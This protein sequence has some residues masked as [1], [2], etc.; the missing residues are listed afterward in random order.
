VARWL[1]VGAIMIAPPS[2][3]A[4]D[5]TPTPSARELWDAYPLQQEPATVTPTPQGAGAGAGAE[6]SGRRTSAPAERGNGGDIPWLLVGVLGTAVALA[7][8]AGLAVLRRRGSRQAIG[9]ADAVRSSAPVLLAA[10]VAA[11]SPDE[12]PR[13]PRLTALASDP[14]PRHD[15]PTEADPPAAAMHPPDPEQPWTAELEWQETGRGARFCLVAHPVGGGTD[16][17]IAASE[18]LAWPPPDAKAVRQMRNEV[19]QM[20]AALLAA[21]WAPLPP[22]TSW[23][24]KRFAWAPVAEPV[25]TGR[26][27]RDP[28]WPPGSE[29][30]H[31]CEI[32]W[33]PGYMNSRFKVVMFEPGRR[34]S[35]T[36][37]TSE[38]FK[39]QLMA[40]PDPG[41]PEQRAEVERLHQL[42][43]AAGWEPAG[44]GAMW[45]ALRF[46]RRHES[47]PPA[48]LEPDAAVTGGGR[49]RGDHAEH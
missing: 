35:T 25:S 30:L 33:Q 6:P 5:R 29:D 40:D 21:G 19:A 3:V 18:P 13:T 38:V 34:R 1:L 31:R 12:R 16:A 28:E 14:D 9:S 44:R 47:P 20:E 4:Q 27:M 23:Y 22:G 32:K 45:S 46:V 26:F 7:G 49:G 36:V 17:L 8:L 15:E 24:S 37:A 2:A 48:Q 39:W 10:A 41:S 11:M 42:I 43:L